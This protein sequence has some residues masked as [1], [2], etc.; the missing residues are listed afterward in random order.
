MIISDFIM[1]VLNYEILYFA[2]E[3]CFLSAFPNLNK[4]LEK[5]GGGM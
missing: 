5:L 4:I 1:F 3:K 2:I